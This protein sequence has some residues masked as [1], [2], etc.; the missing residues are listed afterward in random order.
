MSYAIIRN[1]KK[2]VDSK[3]TIKQPLG[4]DTSIATLGLDNAVFQK[5]EVKRTDIEKGNYII[6]FEDV[7]LSTKFVSV[8]KLN[9]EECLELFVNLDKNVT[10]FLFENFDYQCP[11]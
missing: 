8:C 7:N 5:H 9:L 2:K 4:K 6:T 10:T 3:K 11:Q 1:E